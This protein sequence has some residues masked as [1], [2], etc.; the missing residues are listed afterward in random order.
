MRGLRLLP[1]PRFLAL[2]AFLFAGDMKAG[3]F[4][5]R[6]PVD[7]TLLSGGVL[8][9]VLLSRWAGGARVGAGP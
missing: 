8:A 9:L 4:L 1:P 7:L 2:G 6:F 3:P 5:S